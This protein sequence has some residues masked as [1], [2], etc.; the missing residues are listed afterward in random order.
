MGL[1]GDEVVKLL[2]RNNTISV[3]I[4]PLDHLLQDS[5]ISQLAEILGDLSEVLQGN[6][7]CIAKS[8]PVFWESKVMKT[9]CTSS[10]VSLSEGRVVII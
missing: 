2:L 7:S 5:I 9:L 6:E 10:R 4:S 8:V 3:S 1:L